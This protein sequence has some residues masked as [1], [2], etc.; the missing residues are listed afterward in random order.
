MKK[1]IL[2]VLSLCVLFALTACGQPEITGYHIDENGKLIATYDDDTTVDLGTLTDTIANGINKI[3]IDENGYY[4]INGVKTDIV[5]VDVF[6]VKFVT[7]YD[8]TVKTQ[9][10]KDG[11]K[12]IHSRLFQALLLNN[13][14][15]I[16]R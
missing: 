15:I 10:V 3:E 1:I 8:A 7:G 4:V 12:V 13:R 11:N 5:A 16:V 9:I 6:D 14:S 2:L